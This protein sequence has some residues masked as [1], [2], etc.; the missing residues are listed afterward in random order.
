MESDVDIRSCLMK[1]IYIINYFFINKNV[2]LV[3]I[4]S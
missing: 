4:F 3:E 1:L 2:I